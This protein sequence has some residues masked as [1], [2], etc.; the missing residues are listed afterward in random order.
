MGRNPLNRTRKFLV[1]LLAS[2]CGLLALAGSA[3]AQQLLYAADGAGGASANLYILNPATGAVVKSV[4]PIGFPVTG[5]ALDPT[6]GT[7]YGAVGGRRSPPAD[8]HRGFLIKIDRTTGAGTVIGDMRPDLEAAADITFTPDGTLFGWL[9]PTT[10]SLVL[11][12]KATG[13]ATIIG[14]SGLSTGGS[15]IASNAAGV[16]FFAGETDDGPLRTVDRNTGTTSAGPTLNG[17]SDREISALAFDAAGTLYGSRIPGDRPDFATDLI[18]INTGTGAVTPLG[19][20]V[21]RLDAIV[22]VPP[23]SVLL[24]KKLKDHGEKVRLF[25]QI[26]D[27][28]DPTCAAGQTVK[29]QRKQLGAAKAAKKKKFKA[30]RTLK[31]NAAGEFSTKAKVN[32]TF[33][34]RAFLPESTVCDDVTSRAK[35]VKA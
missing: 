14:D 3:S 11:I 32:Q 5:L 31:T 25:G 23:R 13:A 30:F 4:G 15:G 2:A 35:K 8:P 29:I 27:P 6:T 7:L 18:T 10:D 34:Y 22:F 19:P 21:D 16:L 33:K 28:G 20:S 9:E 24:K 17:T 1:V 12:D 26:T